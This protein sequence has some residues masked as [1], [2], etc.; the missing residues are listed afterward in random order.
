MKLYTGFAE[1]IAPPTGAP[2]PRCGQARGCVHQP[3][4]QVVAPARVDPY[5][6]RASGLGGRPRTYG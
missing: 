6:P 3:T 1:F 2:C 4:P 5:P